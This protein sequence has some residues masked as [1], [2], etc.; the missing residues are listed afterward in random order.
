MKTGKL[1]EKNEKQKSLY[2]PSQEHDACGIGFVAHLKNEKSHAVVADAVTMLENME[3]RGGCGCEPN[4]GD[5]AGILIQLPH[6][7]FKD[8]CSSSGIELP[9]YGSYGAGLIF[10]PA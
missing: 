7:F 6:E 3:H 9:E 5:G 1:K 2:L 10:F 4:T 8:E